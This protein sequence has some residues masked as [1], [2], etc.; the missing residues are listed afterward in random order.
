M[1]VYL[2]ALALTITISRLQIKQDK[3]IAQNSVRPY[4]D[5]IFMQ[6][7]MIALS[8]KI[9]FELDKRHPITP[10]ERERNSRE[11]VEYFLDKH[12]KIAKKGRSTAYNE[13]DRFINKTTDESIIE[14]TTKKVL[15]GL[16]LL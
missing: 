12:E 15:G 6:E 10:E 13:I 16:E 9:N 14:S 7:R 8:E 5:F 3:E 11:Y 1:S 4:A 2:L